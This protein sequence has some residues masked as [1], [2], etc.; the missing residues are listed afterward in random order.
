MNIATLIRIIQARWKI[1]AGATGA[2]VLAALVITLITPKTYV[3]STELIIDSKGQDLISGQLL[4][5]LATNYIPTQTDIIRSRN[6]INKVIDRLRL[7][8]DPEMHAVLKTDNPTAAQVAN[9]LSKG[10]A[11]A[12]NRDSSVVAISFKSHNPKL[13]AKL[14]DAFAEAYIQTNLELR[15]EPAKQVN[16]WYDQQAA[17]L[18]ANLIERQ[19]ALSAYQE[20]HGIV[21]DSEKLDLETA[22]LSELSSLLMAVQ[23]ER[24]NSQSL[25]T[26]MAGNKRTAIPAQAMDNPQI[27]KLSSD[28]AQ[29]EAHL[30]EMNSQV[31]INHPQ[32]LQAQS[33]VNALKQQLNAAL[34]LV[35]GGLRSSIALSQSRET[36][37]QAELDAQK[38]RV[39]QL[40][41]DR[42][43]FNLL[44]QES[45][46]ANSAYNAALN[47]A[48][49]TRL[50]S[51]ISQ[52]DVTVLNPAVVPS[53][54]FS[55]KPAMNILLALVVGLLFGTAAVLCLEWFDR[56]IRSAEDFEQGFGLPVLAF[57]PADPAVLL[58]KRGKA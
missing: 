12:P 2:A 32:Y 51:L 10:L 14:A 36:Q 49:Q 4:P 33:D 11:A 20:T 57:I 43:Q 7:T 55:P 52:T 37:L 35:S 48:S 1:I 31:G 58:S 30:N 25:N 22:K 23:S 44:K 17:A 21:A 6:V 27:Q 18:R 8:N 42:N 9:Y 45:D 39:L 3:A 47:R 50:E 54:P 19:E 13:A 29:A 28:L 53:R 16:Q 5:K 56:R 41:R 40:N 15:T 26:Q 38:E 34:Q 24:L 46:S